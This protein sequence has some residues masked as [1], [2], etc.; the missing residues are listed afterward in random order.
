M[1]MRRRAFTLSE[2]IIALALAA[3][4]ILT[5]ASLTVQ[6]WKTVRYAKYTA[7]ASNLARQQ[8]ERLK[9]DPASLTL[10]LTGPDSER[11]FSGDFEVDEGRAMHFDGR[12][13]LQPLPPPRDRYVTVV[14]RVSWVQEAR[15][16][17]AVLESILP[18]P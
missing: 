2:M 12:L 13:T 6:V 7:F 9:G 18:L 10:A 14:A 17:Q 4:A 11:D 15:D 5:L 1:K 3:I 16:R 8:L